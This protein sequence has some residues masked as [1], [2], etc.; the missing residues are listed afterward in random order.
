MKALRRAGLVMA[1]IGF[2]S[3]NDRILK[4]TNKGTTVKENL[5]AARICKRLGIKVWAFNMFGFPTETNLEA[6]D[7]ALMIKK[8]KPYRSSAA[9][10]TPHPGS[11][12]YEYCKKNDLSLIGDNDDFVKFPEVDKPKIKNVDYNY[13]RKMAAISKAL[14]LGVKLKI[15]IE[16]I[17]AHRENKS[18][19]IKFQEELKRHPGLNKMAILRL[20]HAAGRI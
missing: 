1:S 12:F 4:F 15:R 17:F 10:F 7:T 6:H 11:H 5:T 9:F 2:E 13:M 20:A 14:S 8:I 3:G 18:F 19:K 16:K